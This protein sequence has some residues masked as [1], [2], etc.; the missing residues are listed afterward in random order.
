MLSGVNIGSILGSVVDNFTRV[1]LDKTS[2][3]IPLGCLYIVPTVLAIV[4]FFVPESPRWLLHKG[5]D[6]QARKALETL[7]GDSIDSKYIELEWAEMV[8]GVE[9]ERSLTRSL[10][11]LDMFRGKISTTISTI[12]DDIRSRSSTHTSLL[13]NDSLSNS[14]RSLVSHRLPNILL[15]HCRDHQKLRILNHERLHWL[16]WRQL[17][18]VRYSPCIWSSIYLDAWSYCLWALSIG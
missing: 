5:R 13:R 9:E 2:Y 14:F 8:R 3:Q 10:S 4:L 11:F 12:S 1:R 17:W 6:E 15:Q 16:Y 18:H 7:R